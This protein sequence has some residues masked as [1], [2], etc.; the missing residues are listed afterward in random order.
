MQHQEVHEYVIDEEVREVYPVRICRDAQIEHEGEDV[1]RI[2]P[3]QAAFPES[4]EVD[5]VI[6]SGGLRSGPLQVY[7]EA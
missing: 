5:L 3:A 2:E 6:I 4:S 7:A 1:W